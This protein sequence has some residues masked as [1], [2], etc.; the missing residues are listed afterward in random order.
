MPGKILNYTDTF[1]SLAEWT[2][3]EKH[4]YIPQTTDWKK[5][6]G[7]GIDTKVLFWHWCWKC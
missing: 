6:I 7:T 1:R 2:K 3:K 4:I 5:C